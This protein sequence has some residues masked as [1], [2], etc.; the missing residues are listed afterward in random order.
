LQH[1]IDVIAVL[2]CI[3]CP[4]CNRPTQ[5]NFWGLPALTTDFSQTVLLPIQAYTSPKRASEIPCG[6]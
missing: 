5:G 6:P 4:E 1:N 2:E 3:S